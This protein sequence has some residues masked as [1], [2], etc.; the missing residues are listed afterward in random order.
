MW[1][2]NGIL[3]PNIT[4]PTNAGDDIL[5]SSR[6]VGLVFLNLTI[7]ALFTFYLLFYFLPLWCKF[8]A[9]L[10][11]TI[12]NRG[13]GRE[14]FYFTFCCWR[15]LIYSCSIL[16]FYFLNFQFLVGWRFTIHNWQSSGYGFVRNSWGTRHITV[17]YVDW[18]GDDLIYTVNDRSSIF[19]FQN[20]YNIHRI[21]YLLCP[22]KCLFWGPSEIQ[23]LE[24]FTKLEKRL[25]KWNYVEKYR[26]R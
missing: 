7:I 13:F 4:H 24:G 8:V 25:E 19:Q 1:P 17:F 2:S 22:N 14:Y 12:S 23:N 3:I 26:V 18:Q 5:S 10:L 20:Y 21:Y 6:K 11:Q 16:T 9:I 15:S